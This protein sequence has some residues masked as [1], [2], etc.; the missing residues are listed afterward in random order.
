MA[1]SETATKTDA[2]SPVREALARFKAADE[3]DKAQRTRELEDLKF[4][5]DPDGQWPAD[6]R[7]QR[8]GKT[9]GNVAAPARPCLTF[10]GVTPAIDQVTNS[11]RSA[12]LAVQLKP[13]GSKANQETAETLKGLYRSIELD[14]AQQARIWALERAAKCGRGFYRVL[15]VYA[16]DGDFDLDIK[17]ARILNQHSVFLDPHH[18]EADGSDAD[19]GFIVD[20]QPLSTYTRLYPESKL[21][22]YDESALQSLGADAPEW[23]NGEGE[24]RT[25]RVAEYFC[26]HWD[27]KTLVQ[28]RT[29]EGEYVNV[30]SDKLP[31]GAQIVKGPNGEPL[32][33]RPVDVPRIVWQKI[34][35]V[36]V[37]DEQ[38]WEGRYIPIVKVVGVE[39]NVNGDRRYRGMVQKAKDAQRSKNYMRT[40]EIETIGLASYTPWLI[41]EGVIEGYESIWKTANA[42]NWSHLPF[43]QKS[44]GNTVTAPPERNTAEPPIQA[45]VMAAQQADEDLKRATQTFDPSL[46]LAQS[47]TQSGRAI[48]RL[49]QQSEHGNSGYLENLAQISMTHEARI[50]VGLMPYVYDRPGRIARILGEDGTPSSVMLNRPFVSD[51]QGQPQ[52]AQPGDPSAKHFELTPEAEYS[53]VVS[54]GKQMST[55]REEANVML[56]QLA[57]AAPETVPFWA[58]LWVRSMDFPGKDEIADRLKK[59]L[60][61]QLQEG[62]EEGQIDP[63]QA[64][65]QVQQL[66]LQLQQAQQELQEAQSGIAQAQIKAESAEKIKAAEL[67]S[68][69]QIAAMQAD[70][71]RMKVMLETNVAHARIA[72]DAQKAV[73][74][75][76]TAQES[77][78]AS[79]EAQ[80]RAQAQDHMQAERS[81][82]TEHAHAAEMQAMA[83][84]PK[85]K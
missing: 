48:E 58:D 28:A 36:E 7:E 3:A 35:G 32:H 37:L 8:K 71:N 26:R 57:E 79:L 23:T 69:E 80:E 44:I 4:V 62:A 22:K 38:P 34:N 31:A 65:A 63:A 29:A 15:K 49:Q 9:I 70:I 59:M 11:A 18:Q 66:T 82:E 51:A 17:I 56:G 2:G 45:I 60:P 61:P 47:K 30:L 77:Q 72:A 76:N 54:V 25:V 20:D 21:A 78:Q 24:T 10:D 39:T 73:L 68:K 13:K 83:P 43:R 14:G 67:D 41:A 5:D 27:K 16:N 85:A 75:A 64:Q 84:K 42:M 52:P 40:K 74:A 55:Q 1:D 12:H 53:A 81:Q 19:W 33:S 46:G 50:V 6:I